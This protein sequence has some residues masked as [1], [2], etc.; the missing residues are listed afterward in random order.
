MYANYYQDLSCYDRDNLQALFFYQLPKIVSNI[1]PVTVKGYSNTDIRNSIHIEVIYC[2]NSNNPARTFVSPHNGTNTS[3]KFVLTNILIYLE[4]PLIIY[5]TPMFINCLKGT[6]AM[7]AF[8][9]V[10]VNMGAKPRKKI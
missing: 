9:F 8:F 1:V 6:S 4:K 3:K 10:C 5:S 2:L 7:L